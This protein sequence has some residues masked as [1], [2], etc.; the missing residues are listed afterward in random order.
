M[1][2]LLPIL[3]ILFLSLVITNCGK[4]KE[5]IEEIEKEEEKEEDD[6]IEG[7]STTTV[8]DNVRVVTDEE[9]NLVIELNEESIVFL[10]ESSEINRDRF[11]VGNVI[12][13]GIH[14]NAPRG[15]MRKIQGVNYVDDKIALFTVKASFLD[16]FEKCDVKFENEI[17]PDDLRR[18]G[19][20]VEVGLGEFD[21]GSLVT[22]SGTLGL[23]PNIIFELNIEDF[24]VQRFRAGFTSTINTD[25]GLK[26]SPL[27]QAD[28]EKEIEIFEQNLAP[29]TIIV[30]LYIPI[31]IVITPEIEINFGASFSGVSFSTNYNAQ[32]SISAMAKYENSQWELS[33]NN[34]YTISNGSINVEVENLSGSVFLRPELDIELYDYDGIELENF[35]EAFTKFEI[36][37]DGCALVP[38]LGIGT[39]FELEFSEF[40]EYEDSYTAR[41]D[42]NFAPFSLGECVDSCE[43]AGDEDGDGICA[44]V[45]CDDN[46]PEVTTE[47]KDRDDICADIDCDDDDENI[48]TEDKDGDGICSDVDCDD[49][50]ENI[51]TEDKDEDGICSD[52]DC[53]DEDASVTTEDKDRDG[54]CE[55]IDCD[56]EDEAVSSEDKDGDGVCADIDCDDDD[57]METTEDKD[58]DGIC[59]DL[60]CDDD[61]YDFEPIIDF[62]Q[63]GICSDL[64]CDDENEL[65]TTEDYDEDGVCSDVD[66]ND[67]DANVTTEDI[68]GDGFCS[69][70]DCDDLDS[71]VYV[72]APC[73][74]GNDATVEDKYNENC[75]CEG[76]DVYWGGQLMPPNYYE[77]IFW[78]SSDHCYANCLRE[79][80]NLSFPPYAML[81]GGAIE[82]IATDNKIP[83][84]ILLSDRSSVNNV[85]VYGEGY[86]GGSWPFCRA[87]FYSE[88]INLD[89][90][91]FVV[92]MNASRL[93]YE[94]DGFFDC[95]GAGDSF[96]NCG[97]HCAPLRDI[98]FKISEKNDTSMNG[99]Y[100]GEAQVILGS[101]IYSI[102]GE[103]E[104]TK[105]V[106]DF[107]EYGEGRFSCSYEFSAEYLGLY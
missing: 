23:N 79:N 75:V 40:I 97:N 95:Q 24:E 7:D 52:V 4:D 73:D 92:R 16:V 34:T 87:L 68:D 82:Y 55:D 91:E 39:A 102:S 13:S 30:P 37:D 49:E 45:D 51:T 33:N 19:D 47:D 104:M 71:T 107:P 67:N 2:K 85:I 88:E 53:D 32:G 8:Y 44:D 59:S 35:A 89:A 81:F 103:W 74:D 93:I 90:D 83:Q 63:D 66:C 72:G 25:V 20:V 28:F 38:G 18:K 17:S 41:F 86:S 11:V 62:D 26:F 21:L 77:I 58:G 50:D 9:N 3:T 6:E 80:D 69:E 1:N 98:T 99:T 96:E 31:P 101:C 5:V 64:D 70:E 106:G 10:D 57:E 60:D 43:T 54:V 46:N 76:K 29:I 65:V 100:Q 14:E 94:V 105:I 27:G 61:F 36:T 84:K 15:Y 42:Y 12:I 56:D 78:D 22:L 48:T